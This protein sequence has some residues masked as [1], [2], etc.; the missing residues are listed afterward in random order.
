MAM[1]ESIHHG[2]ILELVP[3]R[4]LKTSYWSAFSGQE[5]TPE[6]RLLVTYELS[7]DGGRTTVSVTT[8]KNPSQEA[9]DQAA[10]NWTSV[11]QTLKD[12]LEK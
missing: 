3:N 11:L 9:A 7:A 2:T 8:D 10:Q 1:L 5:D 12:L 6:N 4:L